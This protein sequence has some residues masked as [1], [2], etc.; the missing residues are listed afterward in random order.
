MVRK[1]FLTTLFTMAIIVAGSIAAFAQTGAPVGGQVVLEADG[2]S[3]PVAGALVEVYR[4][5]IKSKF[6]ADKTDKTDKKGNFKFAGLPF[7][8]VF[9]L[10]IS[11][12]GISPT[13]FPNVRAGNE[14]LVIKVGPGN[15][16]VLSEEEV[17]RQL[18]AGATTQP[19]QQE[20]AEQ[21]KAREEE[22]KRIA[23]IKSKN[24]KIEEINKIV[25]ESMTAGNK[26]FE[27]K[28][29]NAAITN[30]DAGYNADP[31]YV[32]S[33]PAF[34]N[35]K[36]AALINRGTDSFNKSVP[37]EVDSATKASLRESAKQDFDEAVAASN[38]ALEILRT[39]VAEPS[40][41]AGLE[42]AKMQGL[43]NRKNAFRIMAQTGVNRTRGQEAATAFA[44]YLAVETDAAKKSKAQMD[45]ALTLQDSDE[46]DAA[47]AEF[48]KILAADAN[49]VDAIVGLGLTM[50]T[51]GYVTMDT[52]QAKGKAQ[53]Q[54]AANLLQ[55]FVDLA[56]DTHK[57]KQSALDSIAQLKDIVTPQKTKP[58][59]TTKKKN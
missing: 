30:Y 56:P 51:I 28:D 15:G 43:V 39:A 21:K 4:V 46:F 37:K 58:T 48:Q 55:R 22:E 42:A 32:G 50:V 16:N 54:E 53:L 25:A 49:N 9:A 59:T 18:A 26:A 40:Q 10:S 23:E 36:A 12:P 14:A 19:G 29:Y 3:T 27:A 38:K 5:D 1:N 41:A 20:S 6:P 52:D 2:K 17:R 34:L 13:I 31:N 44:E 8:A 24:S 7:G 35:N 47:A 33:A 11:G 57:L 45:L